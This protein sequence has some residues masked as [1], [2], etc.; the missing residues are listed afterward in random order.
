M[1]ADNIDFTGLPETITI[2]P[3][4][5]RA[6]ATVMTVPDALLE[7]DEFVEL[8]LAGENIDNFRSNASLIITDDGE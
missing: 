5:L 1:V 7:G 2:P 4:M 6:C 3:G 8:S